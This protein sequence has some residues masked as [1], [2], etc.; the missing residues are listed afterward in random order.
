MVVEASEVGDVTGE[1]PTPLLPS[2]LGVEALAEELVAYHARFAPLFR[3]SE[4]RDWAEVY[5]RGLL[6]ADGR[7]RTPRRWRCGYWTWRPGPTQ[8]GAGAATVPRG[9]WLDDADILA[10]HQRLVNGTLEG[11]D[12]VLIIDGHEMPKQG[13]HSV[14]VGRQWCGHT[15]KQ[16]DCQA[17][18]YL[19]YASRRGY[20]LL[21]QGSTCP[22]RGSPPSTR[23]AGAP[24]T[25]RVAPRSGSSTSWPGRWWRT[26]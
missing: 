24:A 10:T 22:P 16:D 11:A 18:V 6:V 15:G 5:L 3:R 14:G 21:D 25:S 26:W 13:A 8:A 4:Q 9:G 7:A 12:G 23:T 17:G 20:T 2:T 1:S 19:G